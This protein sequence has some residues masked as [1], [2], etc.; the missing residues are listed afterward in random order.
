MTK[1][2]SASKM[3][4][5]AFAI[6]GASIIFL[7]IVGAILQVSQPIT[8]N[9]IAP[10]NKPQAQVVEDKIDNSVSDLAIETAKK[11]IVYIRYDA[12]GCCDSYG[13]LSTKL[14]G[15]G[16]GIIYSK[17]VD[18]T[19]GIITSR[20]VVDCVFSGQ[21]LYPTAE[22]VTIR[23]QNGKTYTP[24]RV[25]HAPK[26]LDLAI[27]KIQDDSINDFASQA[28]TSGSI[29]DKVVAIGYPVFGVQSAQPILQFSI[30]KGSINNIYTLLTYQGFSFDAIQTDAITDHGA[31]GGGLF[32]RY[33][34]IIGIITWGS[35]EN[36]I[37]IAI[38]AKVFDDINYQ[39]EK[40]VYCNLN[41]YSS[42]DSNNC[43]P[44]GE[45]S[46]NGQCYST[47]ESPR[48]YCASGTCYNN[49]CTTCPS[50][51]YLSTNGYCYPY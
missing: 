45:I 11:S 13:Q 36:K 16:S 30:T 43:C 22:K 6:V 21:C 38:D 47:C 32:N 8:A 50:G 1:K 34:Q 31:S 26:N 35:M 20:H 5:Y 9:D 27:L 3:I 25:L 42:I 23:M 40:F 15:S 7:F 10:Q 19:V 12:S 46:K 41:Y 44:Y 14:G 2:T 29:G 18:G 49:R 37:T 28:L 17:Y 33:G 48:T 39:D 4:F 51:Y 24:I